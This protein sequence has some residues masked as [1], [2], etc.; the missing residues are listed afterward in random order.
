MK[1]LESRLG[2]HDKSESTF[3]EYVNEVKSK[4]LNI[5]L[6]QRTEPEFGLRT[7]AELI[8]FSLD[9]NIEGLSQKEKSTSLLVQISDLNN[10]CE[11]V[12]KNFNNIRNL[13]SNR[14]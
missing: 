10:Y 2:G 5:M 12:S 1:Q 11:C 4:L 6:F 8:G 9:E 7:N 3:N 14:K 13:L